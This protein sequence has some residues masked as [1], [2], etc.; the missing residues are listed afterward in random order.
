MGNLEN[1]EKYMYVPLE[2]CSRYTYV[3]E[4]VSAKASKPKTILNG[5]HLQQSYQKPIGSA[6][7]EDNRHWGSQ[8]VT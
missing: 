5:S 1:T 4:E 2:P 6:G 7:K 3:E 8:S